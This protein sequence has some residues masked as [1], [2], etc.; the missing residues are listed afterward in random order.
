MHMDWI[1]VVGLLVLFWLGHDRIKKLEA[2]NRR[3]EIQCNTN[4]MNIKKLYYFRDVEAY[5]SN[6]ALTDDEV[7][8]Y[9]DALATD[10]E[11]LAARNK[12]LMARR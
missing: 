7:K 8:A 1:D 11:A 9:R 6:S 2:E 3:L 5:E 10:I 12:A 4:E